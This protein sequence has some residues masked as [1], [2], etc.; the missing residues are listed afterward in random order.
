MLLTNYTY[1]AT[2]EKLLQNGNAS[3]SITY[4][5]YYYLVSSNENRYPLLLYYKKIDISR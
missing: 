1:T 4:F 3:K 2:T 5:N